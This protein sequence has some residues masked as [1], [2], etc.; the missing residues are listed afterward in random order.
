MFLLC[1]FRF[2]MIKSSLTD[3]LYES[4]SWISSIGQ[5]Y[6]A[7]RAYFTFR[8]YWSLSIRK[9]LKSSTIVKP[10]FS[11]FI[12]FVNWKIDLRS[13]LSSS[14]KTRLTPLFLNALWTFLRYYSLFRSIYFYDKAL[15][16]STFPFN[17]AFVSFFS[18]DETEFLKKA[19]FYLLVI[20]SFTNSWLILT[21]FYLLSFF[22]RSIF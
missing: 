10:T 6:S 12:T 13:L 15:A 16:F 2:L 8:V 18:F 9:L 21:S 20:L 14:V 11:E 22:H 7:A 1:S 3:P 4:K 5:R 17:I 19:D